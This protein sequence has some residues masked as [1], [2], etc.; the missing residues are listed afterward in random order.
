MQI[1]T[2]FSLG[3]KLKLGYSDC[4]LVGIL[5]QLTGGIQYHVRMLDDH[6][7]HWVSAKE[8][9][10]SDPKSMIITDVNHAKLDKKHI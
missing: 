10:A 7:E 5:V 4:I 8:L 3:Q 9:S 6:N 2:E 1:L